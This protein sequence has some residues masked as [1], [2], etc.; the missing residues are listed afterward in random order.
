MENQVILVTGASSGIGKVTALHLI[1]KGYVV[2]GAARRVEQMQEIVDAGGFALKLDVTNEE[3][4]KHCIQEII[5]KHQKIDV[6]INNAGFAVYGPVE[7]VPLSQARR[8]FD[9]NLFGLAAVTQEVIPHMRKAQKGQIINISSIVGKI[10]MP[11]G[12]WYVASKHALEGWSDCLRTELKPFGVDVV[13]IEPGIIKTEFADVMYQPMV[14]VASEPY[15]KTTKLLADATKSSY[16]KE[17]EASDPIVIA[18]VIEKSISSK[19]PKTRYARGAKAKLILFLRRWLPDKL[20]DKALL[21][22]I[23]NA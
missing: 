11:F 16:E 17:G 18:E 3:E 6:L 14:D 2:Y 20:F 10:Y 1:K 15:A 21:S 4:V 7:D 22:Q 5:S 23:K 13:I 9:V 19:N 8:Q 12:A